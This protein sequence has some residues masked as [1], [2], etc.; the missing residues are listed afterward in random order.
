MWGRLEGLFVTPP[1]TPEKRALEEMK[2][3]WDDADVGDEKRRYQSALNQ[4][5]NRC[6]KLLDRIDNEREA[7]A[8]L[9]EAWLDIVASTTAEVSQLT[10]KLADTRQRRDEAR[11]N[12]CVVT[13]REEQDIADMIDALAQAKLKQAELSLEIDQLKLRIKDTEDARKKGV[14][15]PQKQKTSSHSEWPQDDDR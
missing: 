9:K 5:K 2:S 6:R 10:T 1:A 15:W 12:I 3:E 11:T 14:I 8:T 13:Q 7:S 4:H